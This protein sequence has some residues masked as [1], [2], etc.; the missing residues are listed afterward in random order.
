MTCIAEATEHS[1]VKEAGG[2]YLLLLFGHFILLHCSSDVAFM[3]HAFNSKSG[4]DKINIQVN[5]SSK[6][7]IQFRK[8]ASIRL[9]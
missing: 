4:S 8:G 2:I 7:F 5:Y 6:S 9:S 1:R 3:A